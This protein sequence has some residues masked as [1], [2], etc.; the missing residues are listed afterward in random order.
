M[1]KNKVGC[2]IEQLTVLEPASPIFRIKNRA[3]LKRWICQCSCGN[4]IYVM[5]GNL[6]NSKRH[7]KSCGCR[8]HTI[9]RG[10]ARMDDDEASLTNLYDIYKHRAKKKGYSMNITYEQFKTL[11]SKNCVYCGSSPTNCHTLRG[12]N[13]KITYNGID[14]I[15]SNIGYEL[16]NC[17]TCCPKC[18]KMKSD[19]ELSVFINHINKIVEYQLTNN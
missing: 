2:V 5:D 19:M 17:V 11:T 14:R 6:T 16:S 4:I 12:R 10:K 3:K 9:W 7:V 8:I 13:V 15:D 18:N 1:T